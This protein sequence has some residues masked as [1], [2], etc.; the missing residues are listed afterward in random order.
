MSRETLIMF[1]H[2]PFSARA[3]SLTVSKNEDKVL[4]TLKEVEAG[5]TFKNS[6]RIGDKTHR[7]SMELDKTEI[8]ALIQVLVEAL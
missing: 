5:T 8:K 6:D 1:D 2:N 4:F 3:K 7:T